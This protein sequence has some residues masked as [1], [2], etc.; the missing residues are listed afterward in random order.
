MKKIPELAKT[1]LAPPAP[2]PPSATRHPCDVLARRVGQLIADRWHWPKADGH[3][4][5]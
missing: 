2:V 4:A 1:Y 3:V 5:R